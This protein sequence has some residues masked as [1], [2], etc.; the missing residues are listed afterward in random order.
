MNT[1]QRLIAMLA[2]SALL[3]GCAAAVATGSARGPADDGHSAAERR[4]DQGISAAVNYRLVQAPNVAA[5]DIRVRTVRGR[6][7]LEGVVASAEA[8]RTAERAAWSVD[9]VRDVIVRLRVAPR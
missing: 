1:I 8:A 7:T 9:G 3:A 5:V 4:A 2:L 6:V